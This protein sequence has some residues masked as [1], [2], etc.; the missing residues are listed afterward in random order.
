[1][2][3][4]VA[5]QRNVRFRDSVSLSDLS[6]ADG[7]PLVWVAKLLGVPIKGRVSGSNLF[8]LLRQRSPMFWN[9]FFFGGPKGVGQDAC[10]AIGDSEAAM[11]PSGYIYPGFVDVQEM[12]R[13]ELIKCIN[14]SQSDML[15]VSLG[16]AKGQEWIY[17]NL[18]QLNTPV[19]AHLGAVI[20]FVAGKVKRAP[21]WMQRTGLEWIWRIKEERS[22]LGRYVSDGLAFIG[23]LATQVIPLV[24]LQHWRAPAESEFSRASIHRPQGRDSKRVELGGAWRAANL[25]PVR[26]EFSRLLQSGGDITIDLREVSGIDSAFIGLLLLLEM[27]LQEKSARLQLVNVGP[28]LLRQISLSGA[29]HLLQS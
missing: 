11:R 16:A 13:P 21:L 24:I 8:E 20:N 29:S 1:L 10:L 27:A 18:D 6:L 26:N 12:S 14:D 7:M 3:F 15:V 17:K 9:V 28:R 22:L 25:A 2:N 23:L 19:V 4:I 5:S